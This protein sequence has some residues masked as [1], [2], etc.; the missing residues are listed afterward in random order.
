MTGEVNYNAKRYY[1]LQYKESNFKYAYEN[2]EHIP[3]E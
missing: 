1:F 3:R 2:N